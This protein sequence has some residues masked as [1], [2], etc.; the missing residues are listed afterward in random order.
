VTIDGASARGPL[1][2]LHAIVPAR[3]LAHGKARLG[4]AL[5]AEER[6]AV[7]I[8]LLRW[9]LDVIATLP[10]VSAAHVV[11][12]DP[13]LLELARRAGATAVADEAA[14]GSSSTDGADALNAALRQARAAA[15]AAGA[16]A[17]LY[18]PADLPLLSR[19][20]LERLIDA[21]DAAIAA[22]AGR[23]AVV[24]APADARGGTN[25]LLLVPADVI[26]P[27]FG[28]ASLTAHLL[29]AAAAGATVQV[30]GDPELGFDLDTPDD[31]ERLDSDRLVELQA[32]GEATLDQLAAVGAAE[33]FATVDIG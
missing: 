18:L 19:A 2:R 26:E 11:S 14:A 16:S 32:L 7:V 25:A 13:A 29:S 1:A 23:P 6:A 30:V 10:Q 22:G 3:G 4:S 27:S 8:G 21:A 15:V 24:I 31:L 28:Q 9:T 5:D 20:A 12:A 33:S 17:L